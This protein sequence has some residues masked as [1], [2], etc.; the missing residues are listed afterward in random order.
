[1]YVHA[2]KTYIL[3]VVTIS[4]SLVS[5]SSR[6]HQMEYDSHANVLFFKNAVRI[7]AFLV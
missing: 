2:H 3:Y 6:S 7:K 5:K 1:M 4:R